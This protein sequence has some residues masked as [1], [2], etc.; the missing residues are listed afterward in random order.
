MNKSVRHVSLAAVLCALALTSLSARA[1]LFGDDEARRAITHTDQNVRTLDS[2]LRQLEEVQRNQADSF[3]QFE[4]FRLDLAQL[5]GQIEVLQNDLNQAKQSQHDFYADLDRRVKAMESASGGGGSSANLTRPAEAAIATNTPLTDSPLVKEGKLEALTPDL[6]K[7]KAEAIDGTDPGPSKGIQALIKSW[8][9]S[10]ANEKS[11]YDQA[12]QH[13]KNNQFSDAAPLFFQFAKLYPKSTL[14]PLALYHA[15]L[16]WRMV[17]NNRAAQNAFQHIAETYPESSKMPNALFVLGQIAY[18]Q[19]DSASA[20]RLWRDVMNQ[21]PK[22][23]V[24]KKARLNLEMYSES[25]SD[26][27]GHSMSE[28]E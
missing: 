17:K 25:K 12:M 20:K 8:K 11:Q 4:Q 13:W 22:S 16:S 9:A 21:F 10:P 28:H 26:A 1:A 24:A 6:K 27:L 5:R 3:N 15:G 2:R 7:A 19:G 14:A 18:E 23:E